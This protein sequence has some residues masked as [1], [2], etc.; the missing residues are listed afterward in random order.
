MTTAQITRRNRALTL[1]ALLAALAGL[2]MILGE[3]AGWR[4]PIYYSPIDERWERM[5][6]Q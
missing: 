5:Q 6:G 4:I 2:L 1:I 3:L